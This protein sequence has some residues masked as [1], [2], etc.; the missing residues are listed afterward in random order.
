M[1]AVHE[2]LRPATGGDG[3]PPR[4]YSLDLGAVITA[5]SQVPGV[6]DV[7]HVHAWTITTGRTVFSAHLHVPE[8]ERDGDA[9]LQQSARVLRDRFD[10]YF[11]TL[12]VERSCAAED[13]ADLDITPPS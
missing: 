11:S 5:L 12:Q 9:V 6:R 2:G 10:V 7:H 4:G 8:A 3:E 1:R 13:A